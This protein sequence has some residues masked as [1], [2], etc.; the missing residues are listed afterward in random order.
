MLE[1]ERKPKVGVKVFGEVF[2][3]NRPS[4]G[5]LEDFEEKLET[6][7]RVNRTLREFIV[8]LGLPEGVAKDL[9]GDQMKAV[10]EYLTPKKSG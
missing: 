6:G 8:A 7:K 4:M 3:L 10:I 9:D 1:I 2:E 5:M